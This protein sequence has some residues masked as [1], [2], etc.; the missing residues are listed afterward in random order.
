MADKKKSSGMEDKTRY[1]SSLESGA[2]DFTNSSERF[3]DQFD[4]M[5]GETDY[6]AESHSEDNFDFPI[7]CV[8]K[9]VY[10]EDLIRRYDINRNDF[11]YRV[12]DLMYNAMREFQNNPNF[13][14]FIHDFRDMYLISQMHTFNFFDQCTYFHLQLRNFRRTGQYDFRNPADEYGDGIDSVSVSLTPENNENE[15]HTVTHDDKTNSSDTKTHD[16]SSL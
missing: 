4:R 3:F 14:N 13:M 1:S 2:T 10:S 6:Y 8:P 9:L 11:E 7:E 15:T 5:E 12:F 16:D